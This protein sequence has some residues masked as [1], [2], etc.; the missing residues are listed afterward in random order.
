MPPP[1]PFHSF[2]SLPSSPFL[3]PFFSLS[4]PRL[5]CLSWC[6][7]TSPPFFQHHGISVT[8]YSLV[9]IYTTTNSLVHIHLKTFSQ[10]STGPN[11]PFPFAKSICH[12]LI[13]AHSYFHY[14]VL[15]PCFSLYF[16]KP[17]PR[18]NNKK[19]LIIVFSQDMLYM[20]DGRVCASI[21]HGKT[22]VNGQH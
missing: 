14:P 2:L 18:W 9:Y 19:V 15:L 13:L 3:F 16:Y 17:R 6:S 21:G 22:N 10:I 20:R 8:L 12:P 4:F 1:S 11:I 5:P 7:E